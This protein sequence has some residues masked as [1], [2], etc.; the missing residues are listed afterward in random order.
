V[1]SLCAGVCRSW[2]RFFAGF[3]ELAFLLPADFLEFD[4]LSRFNLLCDKNGEVFLWAGRMQKKRKAAGRGFFAA[5]RM[6]GRCGAQGRA[7]REANEKSG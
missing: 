6:T 1:V 3:F 5:Q 7:E 2:F 4:F